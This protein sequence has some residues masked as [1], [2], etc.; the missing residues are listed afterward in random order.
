MGYYFIIFWIL[1][2]V[3]AVTCIIFLTIGVTYKNYKKILI[4]ISAMLLAILFYYLPFY[5]IMNDMIKS[6][7]NLH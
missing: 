4:A 1:A 5:L 3:M 2:L 7:K 6:L